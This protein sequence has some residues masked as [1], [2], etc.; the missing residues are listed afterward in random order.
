MEEKRER[1]IH[2]YALQERGS[3]GGEMR[4]RNLPK[5]QACARNPL[6]HCQ[7]EMKKRQEGKQEKEKRK[8]EED[9]E[10]YERDKSGKEKEI[11]GERGREENQEKN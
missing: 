1:H 4:R 2:F 11:E 9:K 8:K 10:L 5:R 6:I 3:A 7:R